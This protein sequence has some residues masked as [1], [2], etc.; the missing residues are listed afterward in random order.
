LWGQLVFAWAGVAIFA[1]STGYFL[2]SL[3]VTFARPAAEGPRLAPA[4]ANLLAYAAFGLHHSLFARERIRAQVR[5]TLPPDIERAA[6]VWTASVLLALLCF[7]WADVPGTLWDVQGPAR[8][9]FRAVQAGGALLVWRSVQQ[10]DALELVGLR[11]L[12]ARRAAAAAPTGGLRVGGPYRVIRHP[13]H[14]GALLVIGVL[15]TMT[16]TQAVFAAASATYVL[17][18]IPFEERSLRRL[19]PVAYDAYA[20]RVRWRLCPFLY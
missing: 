3:L 12:V 17:A 8:W 9:I 13:M 5:Q 4:A 11:P 7:I 14:A 18:A 6:Y 16:M 19:S 10:I 15:P 2:F 20:R 1:G